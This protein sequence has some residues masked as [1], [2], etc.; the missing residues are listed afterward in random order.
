MSVRAVEGADR[1]DARGRSQPIFQS[2]NPP[3]SKRWSTRK[4]LLHL[5]TTACGTFAT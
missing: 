4:P 3:N 1:R 2:C 5:L